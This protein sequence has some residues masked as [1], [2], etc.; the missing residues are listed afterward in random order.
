MSFKQ[1]NLDFH[2]RL[3]WDKIVNNRAFHII[4]LTLCVALIAASYAFTLDEVGVY[5]FGI[6]WPLHCF[7]KHTF[8]ISCAFCGM[9]RSF[10]SLAHGNLAQAKNFHP[11]GPFLFALIAFQIPYRLWAIAKYP[12]KISW[13][14]RKLH[15]LAIALTIIAIFLHWLIGMYSSVLR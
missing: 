12:K 10:T 5:F 4:I 7:L 2:F 8:G 3:A 14:L 9:T 1:S 11:I 15:T 6:K 13:P